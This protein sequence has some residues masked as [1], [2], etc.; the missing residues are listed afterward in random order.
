MHVV[1]APRPVICLCR[2]TAGGVDQTRTGL[3]S[4]LWTFI[5]I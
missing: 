3:T 5:H 1:L 2:L 4:T